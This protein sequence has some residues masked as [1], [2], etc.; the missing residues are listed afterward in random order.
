[1]DEY[2]KIKTCTITVDTNIVKPDAAK[3]PKAPPVAPNIMLLLTN[4][5]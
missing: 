5:D 1:L 3:D 2:F 4:E